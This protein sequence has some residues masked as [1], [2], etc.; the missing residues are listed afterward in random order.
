M[1]SPRHWSDADDLVLKLDEIGD[2]NAQAQNSSEAFSEH[3]AQQ[4]AE[5]CRRLAAQREAQ[6]E[7]LH[8]DLVAECSSLRTKNQHLS[9]EL[10]AAQA[11]GTATASSSRWALK[12]KAPAPQPLMACGD[13]GLPDAA[14]LAE[15]TGT[16]H[17]QQEV[18]LHTESTATSATKQEDQTRHVET[19]NVGGAD[20]TL[21]RNGTT[22]FGLDSPT[23]DLYILR[24]AFKE[25]DRRRLKRV[26]AEDVVAK[27]TRKEGTNKAEL[28]PKLKEAFKAVNESC[29][30]SQFMAPSSGSV[31]SLDGDFGY[32]PECPDELSFEGFKELILKPDIDD[33]V[34]PEALNTIK[35]VREFYV[36]LTTEQMIAERTR[37]SS[38]EMHEDISDRRIPVWLEPAIGLVILFNAAC[39]G[40]SQDYWV[41]AVFWKVIEI[42][43]TV[44]F[45]GELFIRVHCVGCVDH[46]FGAD[47]QW[48]F[49]DICIVLIAV[50]D[51]ILLFFD[52]TTDGLHG[53]SIVRLVRLVR[54]VRILRLLRMK[55]FKELA[56]M[57]NGVI[58]G[59]RTLSWAFVFLSVLVFML[60]ITMKSLMEPELSSCSAEVIA[61]E[62]D[63]NESEALMQ[64]HHPVLFASVYRSMFT[65][66][67]CLTGDCAAP[68]GVPLAP[69][70]MVA[71]GPVWTFGYFLMTCFVLFGVFN[72]VMAIFVENTLEAARVN[73]LKRQAARNKEH[74]RVAQE[75]RAIV[76]MICTRRSDTPEAHRS[77]SL[78]DQVQRF[79][80]SFRD[81]RRQRFGWLKQKFGWE[82]DNRFNSEQSNESDGLEEE[83]M[84][85]TVT[86]EVFEEVMQD[87]KVLEIFEDLEISVTNH[88]KLF[89]IIDSNGSGLLD[90]GEIIEGLMKLRGPADKG[91]VV[92]AA[93]MVRSVQ[94]ELRRL[95]LDMQERHR[96]VEEAHNRILSNLGNQ[97]ACIKG[98]C[99]RTGTS[100]GHFPIVSCSV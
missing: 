4:V 46:F 77:V 61:S 39:I 70:L 37:V 84:Q 64:R 2:P 66:F 53:I 13:L 6:F 19:S 78:R 43:C 49:F 91:D 23:A 5:L 93:L 22:T 36:K 80:K 7:R 26:C 63:C 98:A 28:V 3:V 74:I 100:F 59:F 10:R 76:L 25:V 16:T 29:L 82:S 69:H 51:V 67:R 8:A 92:C 95:D 85:M 62:A 34:S 24:K 44:L 52:T 75:L 68:D 50:V 11:A 14:V 81:T 55:F 97:T 20:P 42:S 32:L 56:L 58:G 57:V 88:A 90:V 83:T 72:L 1:P 17:A 33:I 89:D 48:N 54:I 38:R 60:G 31:T 27:M 71:L 35:E 18:T 21:S 47:W 73:Q 96:A 15:S 94:R 87:P 30:D 41:D 45:L 99:S 65:V 40:I 9:E 12:T 86:R 79:N